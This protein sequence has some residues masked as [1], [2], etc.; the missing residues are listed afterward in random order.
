MIIDTFAISAILIGILVIVA[1]VLTIRSSGRD[2]AA[3]VQR[4]RDQVEKMERE[5]LLPSHASREMCCAIRSI[6]PHALH[7]I[8]YQL[9]DDG[10]GPYIKEWLLEHPI[11]E[12][13]HIEAAIGQYRQMVQESNYREMRRSTYPSM[14]DQLDALYKARLGN[15][16]ALRMIDEQIE[17][18]KERYPKPEACRQEC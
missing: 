1:I 13:H 5:T 8:D 18:V 2:T 9:G 17:R 6:Y 14:G 11:P 10:N 15:E 3:E 12:P 4:L 7:G 16:A